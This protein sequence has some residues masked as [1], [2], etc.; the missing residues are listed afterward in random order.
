MY[1]PKGI[2][3]GLAGVAISIIGIEIAEYSKPEDQGLFFIFGE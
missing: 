2:I 1:N 3:I